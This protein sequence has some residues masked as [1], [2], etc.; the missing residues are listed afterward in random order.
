[1]D[2][3]PAGVSLEDVGPEEDIEA[4]QRA[5]QPPT[6]RSMSTV[7]GRLNERIAAGMTLADLR[8]DNTLPTFTSGKAR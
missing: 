7:Y 8:A 1:M 6:D 4:V 3:P 5:D 2:E